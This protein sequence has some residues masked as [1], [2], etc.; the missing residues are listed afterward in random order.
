MKSNL[1]HYDSSTPHPQTFKFKDIED[2]QSLFT[3]LERIERQRNYELFKHKYGD[4]TIAYRSIG[5]Q[6]EYKPGHQFRD[7]DVSM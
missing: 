5:S 1:Q 2:W 6:S 7:R 4:P 3:P